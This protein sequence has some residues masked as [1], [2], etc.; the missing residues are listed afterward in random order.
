MIETLAAGQLRVRPVGRTRQFGPLFAGLLL[1]VV[2]SGCA[3]R[4]SVPPKPDSARVAA[5]IRDVG[6]DLLNQGRTAMAIRKLNQA[7]GE[8]PSDP[9]SYLSLGEAYRRKGMLEEA[10]VNLLRSLTLNKDPHDYNRQE[11]VLNLSALYIQLG[12]YEEAR[13]QCEQLIDDPTFATPWRA[14]TNRGWAEYKLGDF[15]LARLSF[16]QALEFHPRYAPAHLNLGLLDQKERRWIAALQHYEQ[17]ADPK[18]MPP[19]AVAEANFHIAE[20]YVSMG[21]REKAI[22]HFGMALERSPYGK[23]GEQ[24]QSYLE[25]LR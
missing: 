25:L 1:A 15:G 21:Q 18:K 16:E 12:R 22:A 13:Q 24:S 9:I 5:S 2:V 14:L 6:I 20:V 4:A 10:E 23:W 7:I 11:T 19:S 3:H 8:N 17:A